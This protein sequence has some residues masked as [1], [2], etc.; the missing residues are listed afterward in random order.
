MSINLTN[1]LYLLINN[2]T[3][4]EKRALVIEANKSGKKPFYLQL[5]HLILKQN[6]QNNKDFKRAVADLKTTQNIE[7]AKKQLR[8]QVFKVL[9]NV[10]P[11]GDIDTEHQEQIENYKVLKYKGFNE[12]AIKHLH[13]YKE[14]V[15]SDEGWGKMQQ[16]L[17]LLIVDEHYSANY[18]FE[19]IEA[20]MQER[21]QAVAHIESYQLMADT[22]YRCRH[23]LREKSYC[24]DKKETDALQ[25]IAAPALE[26]KV[27]SIKNNTAL[28]LYHMVLCDYY[29]ATGNSKKAFNNAR[30]VLPLRKA[31][32]I[33]KIEPQT[34]SEL[35]YYL[36]TCVMNKQYGS[37]ELH[38]FRFEHF[39][40]QM[41]NP[42]RLAKTYGRWL[43]Y[44][45]AYFCHSNEPENALKLIEEEELRFEKIESILPL[46]ELAQI[47]YFQAYARYLNGDQKAALVTTRFFTTNT[48]SRGTEA[49]I[50]GRLLRL[51]IH[52]EQEN[53]GLFNSEIRSL[54][55]Y[56]LLGNRPSLNCNLAINFLQSIEGQPPKVYQQKWKQSKN[57]FDF[58]SKSFVLK[59]WEIYFDIQQWIVN[60]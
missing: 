60:T 9:R 47:T 4:P 57:K 16:I 20:I 36:Q 45:V 26:L 6:I 2:M 31:S 43:W 3:K 5:F 46:N 17:T 13:K 44:K 28:G 14:K 12:L 59:R 8:K 32:V 54:K 56:N 15:R 24:Q 1:E 19:K 11:Y 39:M 58:T 49:F 35:A 18:D 29:N 25:K 23:Y 53:F 33:D 52:I 21:E 42:D 27:S 7:A 34:I 22:L 38:L 30:E 50:M 10:T 40:N 51:F 37:F 48:N 55:R 41:T